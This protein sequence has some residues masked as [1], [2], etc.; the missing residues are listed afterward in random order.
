MGERFTEAQP[1]TNVKTTS[2]RRVLGPVSIVLTL[3]GEWSTTF[4]NKQGSKSRFVHVQV[5]Y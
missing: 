2:L 1:D 3:H 4:L 5:C